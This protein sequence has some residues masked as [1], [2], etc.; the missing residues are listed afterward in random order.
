[1]G[2]WLLA[3]APRRLQSRKTGFQRSL[4][5]FNCAPA[6]TLRRHTHTLETLRFVERR[7]AALKLANSFSIRPGPQSSQPGQ[8]RAHCC[9]KRDKF[10]YQYR[11]CT[12]TGWHRGTKKVIR[13]GWVHCR[14]KVWNHLATFLNWSTNLSSYLYGVILYVIVIHLLIYG[15]CYTLHFPSVLTSC[16]FLLFIFPNCLTFQTKFLFQH[17]FLQFAIYFVHLHF[18]LSLY[19]FSLAYYFC[20]LSH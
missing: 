4:T 11:T 9:W 10:H 19:L 12:D 8:A 6:T 7:P 15:N 18:P 2:R 14:V 13:T 20:F 17:F 16:L 1:M 5:K 3:A